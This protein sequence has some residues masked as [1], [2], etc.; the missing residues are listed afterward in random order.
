MSHP[1]PYVVALVTVALLLAGPALF[2][3]VGKSAAA[4]AAE[5]ASAAPSAV[6]DAERFVKRYVDALNR[7]DVP[8]I[9]DMYSRRADLTF[10]SVG[11]I[12]RGRDA[13]REETDWL[14]GREGSYKVSLGA[15]EVT[16]LGSSYALVVVP[17]VTTMDLQPDAMQLPGAMTLVLEWSEG[18]WTIVH[19]HWSSQA[20]DDEPAED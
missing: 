7:A 16:P 11:E 15:I 13:I 20:Q 14:T 1:R 19:E 18:G 17:I 8:A 5:P 9:M 4:R 3:R 10:I 12:V 6:R 2:A